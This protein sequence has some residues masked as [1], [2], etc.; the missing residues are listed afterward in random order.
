MASN[1]W[2]W[3]TT[4]PIELSHL[5]SVLNKRLKALEGKLRLDDNLRESVVTK[6]AAYTVTDRDQTILCNATSAAFTVTLPAAQGISGRY[7]RIKKTDASANGVTI[8]GN[9]A[10]TIDGTTTRVLSSQYDAVQIECDGSN[11]HIL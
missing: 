5:V 9:S 7:Y 10:E 11:W 1:Q 2:S 6:T 8:D 4:V 3:V